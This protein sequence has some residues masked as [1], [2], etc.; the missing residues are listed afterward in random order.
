MEITIKKYTVLA[1]DRQWFKIEL[2]GKY[3]DVFTTL[4]AAENYALKLMDNEGKTEKEEI[5]RT[6]KIKQNA[7]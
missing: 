6:Y 4:E 3:I 2:D 1:T 5:I 7:N